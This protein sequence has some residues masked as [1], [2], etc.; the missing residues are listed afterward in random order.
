MM[1]SIFFALL[2]LLFTVP[3]HA[4]LQVFACEPE[5][6][7]LLSELAG[8]KADISVA[9]TGLQDPHMIEA[10]PSLIAKLRRADL[11]VCTGAELETGW[12]P[13]LIRQS[14]NSRVANGQG[15]FMAAEQVTTLDKPERLDRAQGDVHP[16]GNPHIQTDPYRILIVAKALDARLAE[17]DPANAAFYRQR[18]ADFSTR[19]NAAIKRWEAKAAPLRGRKVIV[20]HEA[21]T[22]LWKWLGLEQIGA[23]EPLPGVPPTS[24]HLAGLIELAKSQ[25]PVA[26]VRASYQDARA[27]EW[28]SQRSG[29][30][31]VALPLT[32]GGDK[33]AG[34]LFGF[35]DSIVDKLTAVAK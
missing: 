13:Q 21:W 35:F 34:D 19:W 28:L 14:G 4:A 24:A 30:P 5:W 12:L 22:Y 11:A 32:V 23:L 3:A 27:S 20:H 31:A 10:R 26:I 25:Q 2:A 9:T 29:V 33:Q 6:G 7:A 17:V 18:L 8:D 15:R 1:R 16:E